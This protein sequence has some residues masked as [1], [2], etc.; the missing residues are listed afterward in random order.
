MTALVLKDFYTMKKYLI[1]QLGIFIIIYLF[2]SYNMKNGSFFSAMLQMIISTSLIS[3]FSYDEYAHW[4]SYALSLPIS[5]SEIVG[6]K[7]LLFLFGTIIGTGLSAIGGIA[8]NLL[9]DGNI[10]E[11]FASIAACVIIFTIITSIT[12]PLF[13]K[14]GTER[15]RMLMTLSLLVPF[16]GVFLLSGLVKEGKLSFLAPPSEAQIILIIIALILVTVLFFWISYLISVKIYE[17][18]EF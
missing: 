10:I 11:I 4:D 7:Y 3:S 6:A 12:L 15:G 14:Y 2:I 16:F 18:K 1:K 17:K 5:R 13:F 8:L 9:L